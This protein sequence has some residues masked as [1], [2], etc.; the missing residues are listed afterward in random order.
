M[1]AAWATVL[2]A[3]LV[4]A[5]SSFGAMIRLA[6][7]WSAMESDLRHLT[8]E[9]SNLV[10]QIREDR[11]ATNDRLRWLEERWWGITPHG[12]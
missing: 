12:H 11:R 8:N 5:G 4:M 3:A 6:F 1:S 7:R 10:V 2:V 9:V